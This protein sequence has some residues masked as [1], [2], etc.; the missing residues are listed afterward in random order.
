MFNS[1]VVLLS[2]INTFSC[3]QIWYLR[4]GLHTHK[5]EYS[6]HLKN[7]DSWISITLWLKSRILHKVPLRWQ[8]GI[9]QGREGWRGILVVFKSLLCSSH[10]NRIYFQGTVW[11]MTDWIQA[12]TG[13]QSVV[14][15]FLMFIHSGFF[16]LKEECFPEIA[17]FLD[18]C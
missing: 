15:I 8:S 3:D 7:L 10:T 14:P 11:E 4:P 12:S 6:R 5:I 2:F 9:R 16:M 17:V 1:V 18:C 13:R